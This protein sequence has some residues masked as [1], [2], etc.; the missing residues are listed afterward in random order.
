VLFKR[1]LFIIALFA[2]VVSYAENMDSY[3]AQWINFESEGKFGEAAAFFKK[4][5]A[6]SPDEPWLYVFVG[7]SELKL[8]QY[9]ESIEYLEKARKL[10]TDDEGIRNNL[11]FAYATYASHMATDL[12]RWEDSIPLYAKAVAYQPKNAH[13]HVLFGTAQS[14][15]EMH[16]D[17]LKTFSIAVK[18]G[19]QEDPNNLQNIRDA[20][21][22]GISYFVSRKDSDNAIA[23]GELGLSVFPADGDIT[24]R[25]FFEYVKKNNYK[26]AEATISLLKDPLEKKVL[27]AA[28]AFFKG[29]KDKAESLFKNAASDYRSDYLILDLIASV[30]RLGIELS[31]DPD[32]SV[33]AYR[34]KVVE[35]ETMAVKNYFTIHPYKQTLQFAPPLRIEFIVYQGEGGRSSHHG[36]SNHYSYDLAQYDG[37]S[38]GTPVVAACDGIVTNVVCSKNDNAP[39]FHAN[40][41]TSRVN[42]I[43]I[44]HG[45]LESMYMNLKLDS[46]C[47]EP[48]ETVRAGQIIA[49]IGRSG[50]DTNSH[51]HFSVKT[52]TGISLPVQFTRLAGRTASE[53]KLVSMTDLKVGYIYSTK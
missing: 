3:N 37:D 19:A 10:S 22:T 1:N 13:Y 26:K 23:Y 46:A 49:E 16:A 17:A 39:D 4:A 52:K 2:C 31:H 6:A 36:L 7:Y 21:T 47:V 5:I 12:D 38:Y 41:D 29:E 9:D 28:L 27:D 48:G 45:D 24:A 34:E 14:R 25:L 51:L 53:K 33:E 42:Y 15:E 44:A 43:T 40:E 18:L 8:G 20:V 50:T 32:K 30:Y 35:Y 11:G